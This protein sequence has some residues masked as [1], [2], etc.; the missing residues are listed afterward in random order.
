VEQGYPIK[1]KDDLEKPHEWALGHDHNK[2]DRNK[3]MIRARQHK[4]N[5]SQQIMN[6]CNKSRA[7]TALMEKEKSC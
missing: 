5:K 4:E 1:N 6:I 3:V 7:L 2:T